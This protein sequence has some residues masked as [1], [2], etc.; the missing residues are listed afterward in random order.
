[1]F[2]IPGERAGDWRFRLLGFPVRVAL[3][4]WITALL[5][6]GRLEPRLA[7]LWVACVFI[8]ILVHEMGHGLVARLFGFPSQ[9]ILYEFGGLCVSDS[10][11][12]SPNQRI[13]ILLGGPGAQ[14]LLLGLIVLVG[15]ASM[16]IG[17][18][19]SA[20]LAGSMI[21][22]PLRGPIIVN[23]GVSELAIDMFRFLFEINFLWPLL[24]LLPIWPLDGGQVAV[25]ALGKVN[26][27]NGRRWG[28]TVS[29]VTAGVLALWV[30]SRVWDQ[31]ADLLRFLPVIFFASF[32]FTNFQ[33]LQTYHRHYQIYGSDRDMDW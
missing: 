13:A 31:H 17:P 6:G 11:R 20:R 25:E 22:L 3:A 10:G 21:G 14:F 23:D 18:G 2:G 19:D 28:H 27:R 26:R 32:A 12:Q 24:N 5:L 33:I 15:S 29:F 30:L 1:M 9:L 4:F 8:S 16:G 7:I